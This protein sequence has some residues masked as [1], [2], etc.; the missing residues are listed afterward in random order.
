V[1]SSIGFDDGQ[2]RFQYESCVLMGPE[3]PALFLLNA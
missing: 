3:K 2:L 1:I